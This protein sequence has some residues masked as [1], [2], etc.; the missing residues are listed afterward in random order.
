MNELDLQSLSDLTGDLPNSLQDKFDQPGEFDIF[1]S[2]AANDL[3][4][5]IFDMGNDNKNLEEEFYNKIG[6][7]ALYNKIM[8]IKAGCLTEIAEESAEDF[9]PSRQNYNAKLMPKSI[10]PLNDSFDSSQIKKAPIK[11][12][13]LVFKD[14]STEDG[15][16]VSIDFE[17]VPN[18][19]FN[20]KKKRNL[21]T[22]SLRNE[23]EDKVEIDKALAIIKRK[24]N[25]YNNS[26][27]ETV[28]ASP[29][30]ISGE[31]E[32]SEKKEDKQFISQIER[33]KK[34][35][36]PIKV[37]EKLDEDILKF[38]GAVRV[39]GDFKGL[40][41]K[42]E[43]KDNIFKADQQMTERKVKQHQFAAK[44]NS[45]TNKSKAK[46]SDLFIFKFKRNKQEHKRIHT[47]LRKIS[48]PKHN[49]QNKRGNVSS[50][51]KHSEK[52]LKTMKLAKQFI[53]KKFPMKSLYNK[54]SKKRFSL[55]EMRGTNLSKQQSL[56]DH[57]HKFNRFSSFTFK[58]TLDEI[59]SNNKSPITPLLSERRKKNSLTY[60]KTHQSLSKKID[61]KEI[62]KRFSNII[63]LFNNKKTTPKDNGLKLRR[64][65]TSLNLRNSQLSAY[66]G[67]HNLSIKNNSSVNVNLDNHV[68][69]YKDL[70]LNLSSVENVFKRRKN[71]KN[72]NKN[73]KSKLD[74]IKCI[75]GENTKDE[76][77]QFKF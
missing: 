24:S 31:R 35:K 8:A 2:P 77:K 12:K 60:I 15:K 20:K 29:Q 69:V 61:I 23:K 40:I 4:I 25:F 10:V 45:N 26:E 72:L 9:D 64:K 59:N 51:R 68:S 75:Y 33:F 76:K 41:N 58:K 22:M 44:E 3:K 48:D 46:A 6:Q 56:T 19:F 16:D 27:L 54:T 17:E 55:G 11:L 36:E 47:S 39:S 18:E 73:R 5:N 1:N 49:H 71:K 21:R 43:I 14:H 66:S 63:S 42:T 28:D 62:K 37:E 30:R 53:P 32:D 13:S 57:K 70:K 50:Y 34:K 52:G 7:E 38:R 74:N 65:T 67:S